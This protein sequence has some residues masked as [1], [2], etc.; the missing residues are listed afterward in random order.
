M[1]NFRIPSVAVAALA[2]SLAIPTVAGAQGPPPPTAANGAT[3]KT[4]AHGLPTPTSFAFFR[5]NVFVGAYGPENGTGGGVYR[6]RHG[7]AKRIRRSPHAVSG[8]AWRKRSLYVAS[9]PK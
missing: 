9:G 3:V 5:R 7:K 6:V 8:V 1:H 2:T 4:P